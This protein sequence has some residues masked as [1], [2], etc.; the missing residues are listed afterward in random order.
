MAGFRWIGKE[1]RFAS[2]IIALVIYR[3]FSNLE[4]SRREL[5]AFSGTKRL[6]WRLRF[7]DTNATF[8]Q[9]CAALLTQPREA[10]D[11]GKQC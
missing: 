1:C 8:R 4:M 10:Y 11:F 5:L 2:N 7:F 6:Q 3:S 9:V